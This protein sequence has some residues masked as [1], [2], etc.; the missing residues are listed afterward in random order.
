MLKKV[1]KEPADSP[2]LQHSEE[3]PVLEGSPDPVGDIWLTDTSGNERKGSRKGRKASQKSS[4]STSSTNTRNRKTVSFRP[5]T[6]TGCDR[7]AWHAKRS[8]QK[9]LIHGNTPEPVKRQ[10]GPVLRSSEFHRISIHNPRESIQNG[11]PLAEVNHNFCSPSKR[12][13]NRTPKL[14]SSRATTPVGFPKNNHQP[15]CCSSHSHLHEEVAKLHE[16]MR[17]FQAKM[18][19]EFQGQKRWFEEIVAG[20]RKA[21]EAVREENERLRREL[22]EGVRAEI[23]LGDRRE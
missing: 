5:P 8:P 12:H 4:E 18:I 2:T 3:L 14:R 11:T 13:H 15:H 6:N 20:E 17:S 23:G 10:P 7:Q 1:V 19:R 21:S 9:F 16:E 22:F